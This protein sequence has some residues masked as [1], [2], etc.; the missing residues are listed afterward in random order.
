MCMVCQSKH[1]PN[2]YELDVP[3]VIDIYFPN[4]ALY[5]F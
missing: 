4:A 1:T 3:N 2:N 5:S